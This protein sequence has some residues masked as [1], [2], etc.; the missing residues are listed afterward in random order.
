ME[1]W[2]NRK[3]VFG[4]AYQFAANVI[5]FAL[6]FYWQMPIG[7]SMALFVISSLVVT[8]L[9]AFNVWKT[10]GLSN[11][12]KVWVLPQGAINFTLLTMGLYLLNLVVALL[13]VLIT[14]NILSLF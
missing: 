13:V 7:L 5:L 14:V 2:I 3:V 9:V 6:C 1:R 10:W 11:T 8:N 4:F 12:E